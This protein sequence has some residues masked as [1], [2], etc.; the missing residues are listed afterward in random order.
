VPKLYSVEAQVHKQYGNGYRVKVSI[1]DI[2][3]YIN[4]MM[5]Y[6]PDD[7]HKEWSVLTPSRPAGRGKHA[8][9]VEFNKKLPLWGEVYEACVDAVKLDM[10]YGDD[11]ADPDTLG[12]PIN[13]DDIPF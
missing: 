9:I 3:L 7:D 13:L 11:I 6:P 8:R 10:T 4:G 1:L 5:I 12:D 2:G